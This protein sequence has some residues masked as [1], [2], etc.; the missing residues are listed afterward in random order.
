MNNNNKYNPEVFNINNEQ[1]AKE[2]I[3]TKE[4]GIDT[5]TR[6]EKETPFVVNDIKEYFKEKNIDKNSKIID[7]G[8]GIGRIAKEIIKEIGCEVYG[9]DISESMRREAVKYVSSNNFRAL[10]VNEFIK[11]IFDGEKFDAAYSIWV[12]QHSI[13]P[14]EDICIIKGALKNNSPFYVLNNTISAIPT[15]QGWKNNGIN[16][17]MLLEKQFNKKEESKLPI[18]ISGSE[19]ITNSSFIAKF[20]NNREEPKELNELNYYVGEL[21]KKNREKEALKI[22][23]KGYLKY[24]D[25][26]LMNNLIFAFYMRIESY[27]EAFKYIKNAILLEPFNYLLLNNYG[28]LLAIRG[29]YEEA[30]NIQLASVKLSKSKDKNVWYDLA[31]LYNNLNKNREEAICFQN[32]L[33]INENE[34]RALNGLGTYLYNIKEFDKAEKMFDKVYE[35]DSNYKS[36]LANRGACLNKL[37]RYEEALDVLSKAIEVMPNNSAGYTNRGNVYYKIY[38]YDKAIKDHQKAIELAPN[39]SK[40]YGNIANSYKKKGRF[41]LALKN[42]KKSIELDSNAVNSHFD[43]STTYLDMLEYEKGW[44]EYEWRYKK[45]EMSGHLIKYKELYKYPELEKGINKELVKNKTI[46]LNS[47]QGFGDNIMFIRFAELLQKEYDCN[48]IITTREELVELFKSSFESDKIKIKSRESK[49]KEN[50]D[51]QISILSLPYFLNINNPFEDLLSNDRYLV[52]TNNKYN[53]YLDKTKKNIGIC[54]SAS[55]TGDSYDGKVFSIKE[56]EKIIKSDKYNV[57]SL[58]VGEKSADIQKYGF[59]NDII[60]ITSDLKNFQE[61]ANLINSLDFVISSDT[62]VAHLS[63]ALGKPTYVP[64]QKYPCWRYSCKEEGKNYWYRTMKVFR[65]KEDRNWS[66]VFEELNNFLSVN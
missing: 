58:Q 63:G 4:D 51:F 36:S 2:I 39:E 29:K 16:I 17:K 19:K 30:L 1:E 24:N 40:C 3:L 33:K 5:N 11:M 18:E 15:N 65:Q 25:Y 22:I 43:L 10:D 8:C 57:F 47:E 7:F 50:V 13:K 45:E 55:I 21:L 61:T 12:L 53:K 49:I 27:K 34:P 23:N 60:D 31:T 35:I 59:E 9:I 28:K 20:I 56:L 37:K 26:A 64:L 32:I 6:W 14:V 52:S 38:E 44:I 46:L 54:W 42:Y 66:T 41:D 62:S 48:L